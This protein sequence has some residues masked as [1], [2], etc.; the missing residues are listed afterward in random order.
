M[1]LQEYIYKLNEETRLETEAIEAKEKEL[2]KV[3]FIRKLARNTGKLQILNKILLFML[4][5]K[6]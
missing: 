4:E 3:D 2:D 6:K 5:N 1:T